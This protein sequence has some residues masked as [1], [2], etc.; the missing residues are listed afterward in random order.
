[1]TVRIYSV[2][3]LTAVALWPAVAA[4]ADVPPARPAAPAKTTGP[5][6][7]PSAD[8]LEWTDGCRTCRREPGAEATCS[9]VGVACAPRAPV[10]SKR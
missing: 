8:C 4:A 6:A 3:L 1:M 2:V 7:P 9:N 10:C 5:F